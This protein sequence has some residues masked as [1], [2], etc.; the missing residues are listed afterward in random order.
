[1]PT[2]FINRPHALVQ[3]RKRAGVPSVIDN[4]QLEAELRHA[5]LVEAHEGTHFLKSRQEG[6]YVLKVAVEGWN[7]VYAIVVPAPDKPYDYYVSTIIS[8][9][10]YLSWSRDGKLGT[11]GAQLVAQGQE[12]P[13]LK[14][15]IFIRYRQECGNWAFDEHLVENLTETVRKLLKQ[16]VRMKDIEAYRRIEVDFDIKLPGFTP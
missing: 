13:V 10:M 12:I 6:E 9:E 3:L 2:F 15:T 1:M 5:L 14:P 16:G 7:L 4:I 11:L 8:E